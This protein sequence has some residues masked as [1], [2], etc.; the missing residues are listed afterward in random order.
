METVNLTFVRGETWTIRAALND[1]DGEPLDLQGATV[2]WRLAPSTGGTPVEFVSPTHIAIAAPT[3]SGIAVMTITP[4]HQTSL[5]PGFYE[6]ECR[7]EMPDGRILTQYAGRL[8]LRR[9]LFG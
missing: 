4:A 5:V 2:K 3:T 1:E 7:V 6:H 9:S 8:T